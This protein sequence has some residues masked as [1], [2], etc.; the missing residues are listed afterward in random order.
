VVSARQVFS[1]GQILPELVHTV[2]DVVA[3]AAGGFH[4]LLLQRS[5]ELWS[6]GCGKD[7]RLGYAVKSQTEVR[8]EDV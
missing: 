6:C 4:T 1:D 3:V 8:D 7:G 5:G 2:D